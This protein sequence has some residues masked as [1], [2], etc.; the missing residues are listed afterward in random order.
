MYATG[1]LHYHRQVEGIEHIHIVN[2]QLYGLRLRYD[3]DSFNILE[4]CIGRDYCEMKG[5]PRSVS[6]CF[7][8]RKALNHLVQRST[9]GWL[10]VFKIK[11]FRDPPLFP[12]RLAK[13]LFDNYYLRLQDLV[14]LAFFPE[15]LLSNFLS[16]I[17]DTAPI[18]LS[19]CRKIISSLDDVV[20]FCCC[21]Q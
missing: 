1:V 5:K 2:L 8:V 17:D 14:V 21:I 6:L 15:M 7:V 20:F 3:E 10:F 13:I 19:M 12:A 16:S 18:L 9:I 11:R 4:V